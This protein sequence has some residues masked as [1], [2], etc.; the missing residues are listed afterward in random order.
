MRFH[1]PHWLDLEMSKSKV[2]S[3]F[4]DFYLVKELSQNF[5]QSCCWQTLIGEVI[6]GESECVI[7]LQ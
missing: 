5:I 3:D 4:E 2:R 7:R 6:Y 1:L